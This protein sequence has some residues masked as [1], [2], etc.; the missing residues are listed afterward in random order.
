MV[1]TRA[2]RNAQSAAVAEPA[3]PAPPAA[4]KPARK[5]AAKPVPKAA[6]KP[7]PKPAP[8]VAPVP[9]PAPKS[10]SRAAKTPIEA[11]KPAKK[12]AKPPTKTAKTAEKVPKIPKTTAKAISK[13]P[14]KAL[15]KA[16]IKAS[17]TTKKTPKVAVI[18]PGVQATIRVTRARAAT[19][20]K[21]PVKTSPQKLPAAV[22]TSS[23]S[24]MKVGTITSILQ[25]SP[26]RFA[27][28]FLPSEVAQTANPA[29]NEHE[30]QASKSTLLSAS[31]R[32]APISSPWK[33][34]PLPPFKLHSIPTQI[35]TAVSPSKP[36]NL[37][38]PL[39]KASALRSPVKIASPKKSVTWNQATPEAKSPE[40]QPATAGP[41]DGV[42]IYLDII[43]HGEDASALFAELVEP[44][45]ASLVSHWTTDITHVVFGQGSQTTLEKVVA[46]HGAVKCVSVGWLIDCDKHKTWLDESHYPTD[47]SH[48]PGSQTYQSPFPFQQSNTP[49]AARV[50]GSAP[51]QTPSKT[52]AGA[53]PLDDTLDDFSNS[54]ISDTHWSFPT[55]N[56][57]TPVFIRRLNDEDKENKAPKSVTDSPETPEKLVQKS[58]PP[59]QTNRTLLDVGTPAHSAFKRRL[60]AGKRRSEEF[61][62]HIGSPLKKMRRF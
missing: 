8:K 33:I 42:V 60:M 58:A 56:M 32:K 34:A 14:S 45:G 5:P 54:P 11:P 22:N 27:T 38:E 19:I 37:A 39:L 25:A 40:P 36:S 6:P 4:A 12:A 10:T 23:P 46:A 47:L 29:V 18:T 13:A 35:S 26:I 16:P 2:Q 28:S 9:K 55:P 15:S 3:P 57:Q 30:V 53:A 21:L 41:L 43:H 49:L 44:L 48:I 1:L 24:P 61:A 51:L 20:S 31:P 7:A 17:T 62:P 59:K 50:P 52:T